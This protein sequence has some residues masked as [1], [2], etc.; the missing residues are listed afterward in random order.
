[1]QGAGVEVAESA[2][3]GAQCEYLHCALLCNFIF[4][5]VRLRL[6]AKAKS[7]SCSQLKWALTGMSERG[8]AAWSAR[9][10]KLSYIFLIFVLRS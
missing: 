3:Q 5:I 1:V 6:T 2:S 4:S 8:T 10:P 9:F 7:P